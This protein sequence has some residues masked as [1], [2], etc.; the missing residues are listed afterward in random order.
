MDRRIFYGICHNLAVI[1]SSNEAL[2]IA[3]R[4]GNLHGTPIIL[5]NIGNIYKAQKAYP[6]ALKQLEEALQI[7][8]KLGLNDLPTATTIKNDIES[9]KD[10]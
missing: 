6:K 2:Q 7:L 10:F 3:D 9:I 1:I 4:L 8:N 5:N